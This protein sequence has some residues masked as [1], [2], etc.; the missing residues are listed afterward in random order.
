MNYDEHKIKEIVISNGDKKEMSET[1]I[2]MII[3]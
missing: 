1:I 3:I 2:K